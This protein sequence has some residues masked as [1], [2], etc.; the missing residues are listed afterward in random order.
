MDVFVQ[1]NVRNGRLNRCP[2]N[3]CRSPRKDCGAIAGGTMVS[4]TVR[5]NFVGEPQ[6][7]LAHAGLS[8]DEARRARAVAAY[9]LSRLSPRTA[10]ALGISESGR[11][12]QQ[13]L[14]EVQG[15]PFLIARDPLNRMGF[16]GNSGVAIG[17]R[18]ELGRFALTMTSERGTIEN[19]TPRPRLRDPGYRLSAAT[20]DRTIG[21]AILS[22]G[23]S[24]LTEE[25]TLLGG[26]FSMAPGGATSL[27]LDMEARYDLGGRW[28]AGASYRRGRTQMDATSELVQG[29]RLSTDAW[30]VDLSRSST[31]VRGDQLALRIAQPLRVRSGGY[32]LN[33]P[34]SWDYASQSAGYALREFALAPSGRELDFELA[35]GRPILRGAGFVTANA[36][37]R[38]EPGHI[39]TARSDLGAAVRLS[40]GF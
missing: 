9:A 7:G 1:G 37:V 35:Y 39:D 13:R 18:Q 17:A 33:V 27:F 15:L 20:I 16:H 25:E 8:Y 10:V 5:R 26:R 4:V 22:V 31:F 23:I 36:F 40:F 32:I 12:L 38:R 34:V 2:A 29:G 11:T 14:A 3:F 24:R 6:E 19:R 28:V 21:P 30:A